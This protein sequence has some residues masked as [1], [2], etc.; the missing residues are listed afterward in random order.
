MKNLI[1]LYQVRK[2][3]ETEQQMIGNGLAIRRI[4]KDYISSRNVRAKTEF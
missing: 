2:N 1:K 4:N 3:K